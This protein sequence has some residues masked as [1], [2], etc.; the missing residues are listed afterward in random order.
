MGPMGR[1]ESLI[2]VMNRT[3]RT[4]FDVSNGRLLNGAFGMPVVRLTTTGRRSGEPRHT[5]L[6]APVRDDERI[7]LVASFGG[8]DRH[9]AWYL[10][11]QANPRVTAL[12][13]GRSREMVARTASPEE[14]A[15]LWPR[16]LQSYKGYED[17]TKRTDREIP[18]VILEPAPS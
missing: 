12:M 9:P 16:I 17:Y 1:R 7:V 3:H 10:N 4:L 5:M 13:K 6:T 8:A 14:R 11:L 18:V 15:E 2:D